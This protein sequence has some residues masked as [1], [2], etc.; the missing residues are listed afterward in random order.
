MPVYWCCSPKGLL[1]ARKPA[2]HSFIFGLIRHGRDLHTRQGML[3][4]WSQMWTRVTGQSAAELLVALSERILRTPW[5]P[6]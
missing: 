1:I 5:R 4:D 6:G 2:T 3:R